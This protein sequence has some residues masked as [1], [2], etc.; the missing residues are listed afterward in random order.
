[1]KKRI[2]KKMLAAMASASVCLAG[3]FASGCSDI[4]E[5]ESA[6]VSE[7]EES[8]A[9]IS[10]TSSLYSSALA[11]GSTLTANTASGNYTIYATSAKPVTVPSTSA[12]TVNGKSLDRKI[13]LGGGG[14]AGSYRCIGFQTNGSATV[15]SF[16]AGASGR[17]LALVNAGGTVLSKAEVTSSIAS[18][19][20]SVPSNGTYYI[21]STA[22]N[23]D[24]YYI[25]TSV[26]SSS[27]T[28]SSTSGT[29]SSGTAS[30]SSSVISS[31]DKPVGYASITKPSNSVTVSTKS[32]LVNYAKK[33]GYVIY[34]NGMI[35][36]SEGYLPSSAGG[37]TSKLDAL[38]K[39]STSGKYT[40]YATFRDAY[41][42]GCSASTN[43]KSSSSPASS[44]GKYLWACNEAYGKII[45]LTVAS[46]T[47]IIGLTSGSG[48]K[49]GA[50]SIS[51]VSNVALR[52]LTI[53][54]AYDPFPHHEANDGF[55]AQHDC[56]VIQGTSSNIW[57]DHCTLQDTMH[58][59]TVSING[60]TEKW[61]TYDGLLDMKGSVKN[62]VVSYCKFYDHDKT[63][64][65]GSSDTDGSN[66]TRTVTLHHNY[67]LNCGQR[68]P[69][70]RNTR[71]H[72]FNNYYEAS[73]N[74][75]AQQYAVGVRKNALIVAENNT[76]GSGIKYSFKDSYGT[77]YA[78]GNADSSSKGCA[79]ATSS[80]KPFTPSYSYTLESAAAS[81][82]SVVNLAG[83]GK[84]SVSK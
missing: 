64:L 22:S 82:S 70:V 25:K 1:M 72:L 83:A 80:S 11:A 39:S 62:I 66:A 59:T 46:D 36:M 65:I 68:L 76:F 55:N 4:A 61:Q 57:I 81:K 54:D 18:Y 42:K 34:V 60:G 63:M 7:A 12:V 32:D 58:C 26:G 8:R 69:M 44:L 49:G 14:S 21:M 67:F 48:I 78:S 9:A 28:G 19:E 50:L 77:L 47:Q 75:Y 53:Q 79:S 3:I 74:Y 56:I 35:D 40:S 16:A 33:G 23:I 24:I 38:V 6:A 45:K 37:A 5:Q 51:S 15:T 43:D 29:S 10:G 27:S 17:Y 52:N 13:S 84:I 2:G 31:S 73:G 71:L 41:A 30:S 20:F